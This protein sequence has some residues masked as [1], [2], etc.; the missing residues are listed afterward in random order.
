MHSS[1]YIET[2]Q[3]LHRKAQAA[4]VRLQAIYEKQGRSAQYASEAERNDFIGR[5]VK[6][7]QKSL[8]PK[9]KSLAQLQ[10]QAGEASAKLTQLQ[11][12]QTTPISCRNAAGNCQLLP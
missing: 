3:P 4:A 5:E 10:Q 11:Q 7:L 9:E 12:V 6:A 8:K 2:K 1:P